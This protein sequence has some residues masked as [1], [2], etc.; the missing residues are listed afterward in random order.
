MSNLKELIDH[1][2][3]EV[4]QQQ[5][6][7]EWET[8]NGSDPIFANLDAD[9]LFLAVRQMADVLKKDDLSNLLPA[10]PLSEDNA[11]RLVMQWENICTSV[12]GL[13]R[14]IKELDAD[15]LRMQPWGDFDVVKLN[16]LKQHD[17]HVSFWKM[18]IS[19]MASMT[20]DAWYSDYQATV[21]NVDQKDSF[22]I[23]ITLG[24]DEP[25]MP[26]Q[27]EK[28]EICPC[29]V[30]TLIMLQT[31]DKDSLK[32]VLTTQGDF[33][34]AHYA[35]LRETLRVLLP[36]GAEL[37]KQKQSHRQMLKARLKKLFKK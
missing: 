25:K 8:D 37:P 30:S 34:L 7:T 22:F 32:R 16:Q 31:R 24:D 9:R 11:I 29:P 6:D 12:T 5:D 21:I 15:I 10:T 3:E 18:P 14:H 1:L 19:F 33:A 28:V 17:C 23:T 36:P 27:A 20:T 4:T 2:Y 35:E 13:N 26:V